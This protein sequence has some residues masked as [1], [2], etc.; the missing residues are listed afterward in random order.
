MTYCLGILV[1]EGLVMMADTRTNAGVDN[2]SSYRKLRV[3]GEGGKRLIAV[4]SAGNLSTSQAALQRM[5]K[6]IPNEETLDL[7]SWNSVTSIYEAALAAGRALRLS[8]D[9]IESLNQ[10]SPIN[11]DATLLVGG[12][13]GGEPHRLFLV[14]PEGNVIEC[15]PDTPYLQIGETKYGKPILDRALTYET[16]IRDAVKIGLI[17]FEA[18]MRANLAVGLPIDLITAKSGTAAIEVQHRI[19]HGDSYFRELSDQ[20]AEAMLRSVNEMPAPPY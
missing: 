11:F 18:T 10:G 7:D 19:D 6:G 16:G 17:S 8:R 1:R 2:I 3:F 14:Y 5:N 9:G 12:S 4:A 15:G 20:W 13:V